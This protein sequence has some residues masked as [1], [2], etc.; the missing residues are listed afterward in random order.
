MPCH[1]RVTGYM[2]RV[3]M[4]KA[5]TWMGAYGAGTAK[6]TMLLSNIPEVSQ[7][8]RKLTKEIIRG[9]DSTGVVAPAASGG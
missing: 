6:A 8:S 7:L 4:H 9:L 3:D 2:E 5:S 1:S